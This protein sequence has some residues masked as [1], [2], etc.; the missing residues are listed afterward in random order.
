VIQFTCVTTNVRRSFFLEYDVVVVGGG[1]GGYV[2]AI[3]AA[4]CGL[5]TALVEKEDLGGVC[6][7]WG[8][9]PSKALLQNAAVIETLKQGEKFGFAFHGLTVDY[10]T[11]QT[12]SRDVVSRLRRGVAHLLARGEVDVIVG[13]ATF[14]D[15]GFLE[16]HG[17]DQV[18]AARYYI[19]ATGGSPRELRE[20]PHDGNVVMNSKDVLGMRDLPE[21]VLIV[22]G[23]ATGCEFAYLLNAYGVSVTLADVAENLI[24]TEDAEIS[25]LLARSFARRGIQVMVG[26]EVTGVQVETSMVSV[27]LESSSHGT[28]Q[29]SFDRLIVAVGIV[30][31]SSEMNLDKVGVERDARGFIMVDEHMKTSQPNI[32]AIGDV[33]GLMPLA[34]VASAQ[35]VMVAE[36]IVGMSVKPLDY[37]FVPR[38]VYTHP[39]VASFGLS[40]R[41]AIDAGYNVGVSRFPF[42]ASA[43]AVSDG[44]TEG[45]AKLVMDNETDGLLGVHIIGASATEMVHE[46][47]IAHSLEGKIADIG[48]VI[49]AH[50]TLSEI[51]KEASLLLGGRAIHV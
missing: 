24:P 42:V 40:E 41:Q 19:I 13:D 18:I 14:N 43:K 4:Q 29:K 32:Y 6:L 26:T 23:G 35:G 21:S 2:A 7:N 36:D 48:D 49:H 50:P 10:A 51:I 8:C 11:A 15:D 25:R 12:R 47:A 9:I 3:R 28:R 5:K 30:P 38:A 46:A 37:R 31:N 20:A 45:V 27:T 17:K 16:L 44:E 22:G 33:T 1:P 39:E 34:H